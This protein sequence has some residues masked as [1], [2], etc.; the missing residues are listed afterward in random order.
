MMDSAVPQIVKRLSQQVQFKERRPVSTLKII[1]NGVLLVFENIGIEHETVSPATM[2]N[3]INQR[4]N[5]DAQDKCHENFD[6]PN[7]PWISKVT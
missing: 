2:E 6:K 5:K 1:L 3:V 7:V 4:E